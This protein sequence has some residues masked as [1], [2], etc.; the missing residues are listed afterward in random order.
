M[1]LKE[2]GINTRQMVMA[3]ATAM[4]HPDLEDREFVLQFWLENLKTKGYEAEGIGRGLYSIM[5][6]LTYYSK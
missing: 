1:M 4:A 2:G 5:A 3:M 6:Q